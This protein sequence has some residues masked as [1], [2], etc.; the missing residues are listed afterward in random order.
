MS[1]PRYVIKNIFLFFLLLF[2]CFL[3]FMYPILG[4]NIPKGL[5]TL[6]FV[7]GFLGGVITF[8]VLLVS[9]CDTGKC[10]C[11]KKEISKE[12]SS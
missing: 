12:K 7:C 2:F 5:D 11:D 10:G 8:I 3:M 1:T 6:A 9:I 4:I